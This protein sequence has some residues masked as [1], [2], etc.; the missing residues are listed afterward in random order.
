MYMFEKLKELFSDSMKN[1]VHIMANNINIMIKN[2]DSYD[3]SLLL[4]LPSIR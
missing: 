4:F 1:Y 2:N 3:V